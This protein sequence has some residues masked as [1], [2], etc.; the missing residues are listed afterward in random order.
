M[1]GNFQ[2]DIGL[3]TQTEYVEGFLGIQV[4]GYGEDAAAMPHAHAAEIG[5]MMYRP[6]DPDLDPDGQP[7]PASSAQVLYWD[8]GGRQFA[9][10]MN[11]PRVTAKAPQLTKGGKQIVVKSGA[12]SQWDGDTGSFTTYVPY[13]FPGDD[14]R[15]TPNKACLFAIDTR[16]KGAET[17][18]IVHGCGSAFVMMGDG[19]TTLKNKAGDAC[20]V[21]DSSGFLLNG[22]TKVY[23][24]FHVGSP[25]AQPVSLAPGTQAQI[26]ALQV[27]I[28]ALGAYVAALT[29]LYLSPPT[30]TTYAS[31]A[32]LAG[33]AGAA[34]A[35]AVAAG[36]VTVAASVVPATSTKMVAD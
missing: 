13:D 14:V 21:L 11:D 23:G 4:D 33:A 20:L 10:G 15:K 34:V 7:L 30:S 27:Q 9:C 8:E 25:A 19:T 31:F 29:S 36:A 26:A 6:D 3:A 5:G 32:P 12:F 18:Q 22:N 16:T 28:A 1:S 2:F 35:A 24:G 17:I